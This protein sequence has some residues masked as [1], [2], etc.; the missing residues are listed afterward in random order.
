MILYERRCGGNKKKKRGRTKM[1]KVIF[2]LF[3]QTASGKFGT[4]VVFEK[5]SGIDVIAR[6]EK[7]KRWKYSELRKT[8]LRKF[9]DAA[10]TWNLLT[11]EQ[12]KAY[13]EG[14][15]RR[16]ITPYNEYMR[17]ELHG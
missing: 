1:A 14:A 15:R 16:R 12:K 10:N 5:M 11:D 4:G 9:S 13:S 8:Q 2:P 6:V 7:L 17:R 3:S